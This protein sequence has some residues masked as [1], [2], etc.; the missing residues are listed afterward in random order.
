MLFLDKTFISTQEALCTQT[1]DDK[2]MI[3][4]VLRL[5]MKDTFASPAMKTKAD[6]QLNITALLVSIKFSENVFFKGAEHTEFLL[7]TVPRND[8]LRFFFPQKIKSRR[9]FSKQMIKDPIIT[10]KS[11]CT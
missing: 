8:H 2:Q 5:R 3:F 6:K 11:I 4:N 1:S 7:L 9:D 10:S